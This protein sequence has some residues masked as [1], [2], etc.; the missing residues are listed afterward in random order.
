MTGRS[1][2]RHAST[3]VLKG[4]GIMIEGPSG[5]GK[6]SLALALMALGAELVADDRTELRL[7]EEG[8]KVIADAPET[9]PA[10]I[11]AR[12]VGLLPAVLSGPAV[13][14]LVV[15]LGVSETARLP[16][17]HVSDVLG[18]S[19]ALMHRP[20]GSYFPQALLQYARGRVGANL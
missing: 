1:E 19:I 2:I 6:S 12:G 3:V 16:E 8:P 5:S 17:A 11:E 9:L 14:G 13:L 18:Q 10:L 20:A 7:D 4:L 15:D